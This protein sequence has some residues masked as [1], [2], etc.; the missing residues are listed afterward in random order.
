MNLTAQRLLW[1]KAPFSK[2]SGALYLA[3]ARL[4]IHKRSVKDIYTDASVMT[5]LE[6]VWRK[7]ENT[8]SWRTRTSSQCTVDVSDMI[9]KFNTGKVAAPVVIEYGRDKYWLVS[10]EQQL[11]VARVSGIIPK[12]VFV[13]TEW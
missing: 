4:N 2:E 9:D 3:A 6:G 12:V 5:M 10:G 1:E 11:Q 13:R 8:D 7:L